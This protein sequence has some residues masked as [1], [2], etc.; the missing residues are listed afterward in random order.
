MQRS[1]RAAMVALVALFVASQTIGTAPKRYGGGL[2]VDG[3]DKAGNQFGTLAAKDGD[4]HSHPP[5]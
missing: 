1:I 5:D 4:P 3:T 2:F